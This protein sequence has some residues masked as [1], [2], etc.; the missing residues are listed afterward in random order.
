[1]FTKATV[2]ITLTNSSPLTYQSFLCVL[3][4]S[5][6]EIKLYKYTRLTK[7]DT[8]VS[9]KMKRNNSNNSNEVLQNQ[10]RTHLEF[11]KKKNGKFI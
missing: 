3:K 10:L 5:F 8:C 2:Q 9:L 7:C 11:I 1:M 4:T 6:P